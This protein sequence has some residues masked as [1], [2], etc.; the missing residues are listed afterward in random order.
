MCLFCLI[1]VYLSPAHSDSPMYVSY[2]WTL[3]AQQ[4]SLLVII[5]LTLC[6]TYLYESRSIEIHLNLPWSV[7]NPSSSSLCVSGYTSYL[8]PRFVIRPRFV[9]QTP[10]GLMLVPPFS[11]AKRNSLQSKK[12]E[13]IKVKDCTPTKLSPHCCA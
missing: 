3:C 2:A 8:V 12:R 7:S 6:I 10:G 1:F 5:T 11:Q 13:S 4:H 9:Y